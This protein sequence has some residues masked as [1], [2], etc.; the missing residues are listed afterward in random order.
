MRKEE[1]CLSIL[2]P[3][4][5]GVFF[6][7]KV[8]CFVRRKMNNKNTKLE[9][10]RLAG[11]A[12]FTA[13]ALIATIATKWAQIAFLTFDAKDAVITVAAY[14]Y[15]PASGIMM[16][17]ATSVIETLT[18]G[19]DTG[20]YGL[21][22][23]IL[24][25]VAFSF[26]ASIIYKYKRDINGALIGLISAVVATTGIML[27]ANMF[28]TPLY[29]SLPVMD[30]Y[31]MKMIPTLLLPFNLAKALMNAAIAMVL[32]KPVLVALSKTHLLSGKSTRLEFNKNSAIILIAGAIFIAA[33]LVIFL[34]LLNK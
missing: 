2:V 29:F 20:W 5:V 19:G 3:R 28:I 8:F 13:L 12:I 9:T 15:G 1:Y 23:N 16:A 32:Y 4:C 7:T 10:R 25:S 24:S 11:L 14:I 22:M 17:F 30:T 34:L 31:V 26:T 18:F 27:L 21:L 6:F 33:A